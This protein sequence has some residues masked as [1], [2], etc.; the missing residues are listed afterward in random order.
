MLLTGDTL[1]LPPDDVPAVAHAHMNS[2]DERR[3]NSEHERSEF[4]TH[5][6]SQCKLTVT[7]NA[8]NPRWKP[9]SSRAKS[10]VKQLLVLEEHRRLRAKQ[11]LDHLWFKHPTYVSELQ[12]AYEYAI[13]DW[14]QSDE[15]TAACQE[16]D[17]VDIIGYS[18]MD[19]PP[20]DSESQQGIRSEHFPR[21]SAP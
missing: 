15:Q 3:Q 17:T 14:K 7:D 12:H 2:E 13:R 18:V 10:F 21:R 4:I 8:A 9:L 19:T 16:I 1:F 6:A 11:A 20:P 5:F